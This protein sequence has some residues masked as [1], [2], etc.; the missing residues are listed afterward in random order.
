MGKKRA[1]LVSFSFC[2]TKGHTETSWDS[3]FRAA[4]LYEH[5]AFFCCISLVPKCSFFFL[6]FSF[7]FK[8]V[9]HLLSFYLQ[10]AVLARGFD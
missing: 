8:N 9:L 3:P 2:L 1:E 6:S 10:S 5:N 4:D 7:L